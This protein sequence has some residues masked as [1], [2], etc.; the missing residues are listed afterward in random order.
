MKVFNVSTAAHLE[1]FSF[2]YFKIL[3]GHTPMGTN[4]TNSKES[5]FSRGITFYFLGRDVSESAHQK[6]KCNASL[7]LARAR[8]MQLESA[9]VAGENCTFTFTVPQ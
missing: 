9:T 4:S 5:S 1:E 8:V 6:S 3:C 2:M 7:S